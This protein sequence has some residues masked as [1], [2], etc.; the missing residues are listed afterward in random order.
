MQTLLGPGS[1]A[2]VEAVAAVG[3]EVQALWSWVWS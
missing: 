3:K 2:G 1:L